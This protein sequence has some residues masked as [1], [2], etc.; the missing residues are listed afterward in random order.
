MSVQGNGG[1]GIDV[2][3]VSTGA[4]ASAADPTVPTSNQ[5]DAMAATDPLGR[6]ADQLQAAWQDRETLVIPTDAAAGLLT[7]ASGGGATLDVSTLIGL[8]QNAGANNTQNGA[9]SWA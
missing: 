5:L 4:S 3:G 8:V 6:T 2:T 1:G 9:G 7:D